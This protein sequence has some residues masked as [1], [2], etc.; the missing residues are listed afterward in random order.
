VS[1][2]GKEQKIPF[3]HATP[4]TL[5]NYANATVPTGQLFGTW[6]DGNDLYLDCSRHF[7]DYEQALAFGKANNQQAIW[8]AGNNTE[9]RL[10]NSTTADG[11]IP[12]KWA[13]VNN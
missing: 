13:W 7:D 11:A 4:E 9:I 1:E 8:D 2:E 3:R 5:L 10:D 12:A 6:I